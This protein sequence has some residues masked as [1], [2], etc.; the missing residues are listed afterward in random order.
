MSLRILG[1]DLR[2]RSFV[3]P[4]RKHLRP[5]LAS[6]RESFFNITRPYLEGADFLDLFAGSGIMGMEALSRG[7]RSVTFVENHAQSCRRLKE[8]LELF[9][10]KGSSRIFC[11]DVFLALLDLEREG[12]SFSLIYLDPPYT[13]FEKKNWILKLLSFFEHTSLLHQESQLFIETPSRFY[14]EE[15][16]GQNLLLKSTRKCGQSRLHHFFLKSNS[17]EA[18]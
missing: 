4:Q 2:G 11:R 9:S 12:A 10:L 16:K 7:V 18:I 1:G 5:T 6:L 8:N 3:V 15:K 14:F 17:R 13:Y